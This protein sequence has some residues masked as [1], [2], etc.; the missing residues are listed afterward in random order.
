MTEVVKFSNAGGA[1]SLGYQSTLQKKY[2][3]S[4][5]ENS[6]VH[7]SSERE[8]AQQKS[9][10]ICLMSGQGETKQDFGV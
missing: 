3:A 6:R 4:L 7:Y 9:K 1:E 8:K 2:P 5:G 10:F